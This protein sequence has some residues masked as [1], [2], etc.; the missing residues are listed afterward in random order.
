MG[1][2]SATA[3]VLPR[4]GSRAR[5]LPPR[6]LMGA[7]IPALIVGAFVATN[8][9]ASLTQRRLEGAWSAIVARGPL[10][11]IALAA[12]APAAGSPVARLAI[13]ALHLDVI[14]VEGATPAAMRRG[15]AH[16]AASPLPGGAGVSIV[17]GNRLGFG[18]FFADLDRL[19]PGDRILMETLAGPVA[20]VVRT[21]ETVPAGRLDL[22]PAGERRGLMLFASARRWGGPD[23]IVVRAEE[24]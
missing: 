3:A 18:G 10:D 23:R 21:V 12:H 4:A 19:D 9:Q 22:A 24:E 2:V 17:T 8:V 6:W 13:P 11:P 5:V 15:P 14:V 1:R 16:L 20:F 7:A